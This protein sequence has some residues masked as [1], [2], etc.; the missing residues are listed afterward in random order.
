MN[1]VIINLTETLK[2][3]ID[4]DNKINVINLKDSSNRLIFIEHLN[5]SYSKHQLFQKTT[6]TNDNEDI[7]LN[8]LDMN[9]NKSF[10]NFLVNNKEQ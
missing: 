6:A 9:M 3:Y 5:V 4:I 7:N 10:I 8:D 1:I 2:N